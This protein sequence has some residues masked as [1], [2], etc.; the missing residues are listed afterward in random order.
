MSDRIFFSLT[1]AAAIAMVALALVYPQGLGT[2][3]PKPFGHTPVYEAA[4]AAARAGKAAPAKP[5]QAK[6]RGPL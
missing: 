3:S 1:T 6:L 2:R 4:A 5:A